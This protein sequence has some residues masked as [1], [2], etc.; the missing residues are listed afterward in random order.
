MRPSN[1]S[2]PE[3]VRGHGLTQDSELVMLRY[4]IAAPLTQGRPVNL[5]ASSCLFGPRVE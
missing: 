5:H 4:A 2:R 1:R 3:G